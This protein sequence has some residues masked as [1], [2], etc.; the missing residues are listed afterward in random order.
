MRLCY[1]HKKAPIACERFARN[2]NSLSLR[3]R[4]QEARDQR[5]ER[6]AVELFVAAG[7]VDHPFDLL[8]LVALLSLARLDVRRRSARCKAASILS[9]VR[10]VGE[11][12]P[13]SNREMVSCRTPAS[14]ANSCC[15]TPSAR[16]CLMIL[17]A[18]DTRA[19][20][21]AGQLPLASGSG[22]SG[23]SASSSI[24]SVTLSS[25]PAE[26]WGSAGRR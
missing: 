26:S 9:T 19:Y 21:T 23:K 6:E 3:H 25:P 2:A 8:F 17:R 5:V 1:E 22:N 16:R 18:S 15:E 4:Q 7:D 20:S 24:A 14:R 13:D 10:T 12:F 11:C